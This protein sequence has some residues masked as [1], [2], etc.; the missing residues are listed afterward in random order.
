MILYNYKKR[1]ANMK[2]LI[3][4]ILQET[5]ENNFS[6]MD[7]KTTFKYLKDNKIK[8]YKY[9]NVDDNTINN[10]ENS[11]FYLSDFSEF[12]DPFDSNIGISVNQLYQFLL[13]HIN[14]DFAGKRKNISRDEVK[15]LFTEYTQ[16]N[17]D[18]VVEI[19]TRNVAFGEF[20]NKGELNDEEILRFFLS[21]KE[22]LFEIIDVSLPENI[23][24]MEN[25]LIKTAIKEAMSGL[26]NTSDIENAK[27]AFA[28]IDEPSTDFLQKSSELAN[29]FGKD[30]SENDINNV[31]NKIDE[32]IK[33]LY[34][35]LSKVIGVSCFSTSSD[36][37]L[38]WSH[39]A[40]KH[41]GVCIEYDF[42]LLEQ[43]ENI[44]AFL[45]PVMYS[46]ERP[47]LPFEKLELE[48]GQAKQESVIRIM[49]DLIRAILTKSKFW[50]YE[51]EW[52]F[53]ALAEPKQPV[54][55]PIISRIF[56]GSNI[57]EENFQKVVSAIG[58]RHIPIT[59]Y[60]LKR[61]KYEL[62]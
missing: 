47:L 52:R 5:S 45:L 14:L 49:P 41:R 34:I 10:I 24:T 53:I 40:N 19:L 44:N 11:A 22:L 16:G 21:N 42:S 50:D 33:G 15:S 29:L 46:N 8:L 57:T 32:M 62:E 13:P 43:L 61:D 39:Y 12:N 25:S 3:N 56:T 31:Y 37:I 51:N 9:C 23:E 55:L 1:G 54:K 48:N 27:K 4:R 7:C 6:K 60:S 58:N 20:I 26:K 36:N 18:E 2:N 17:E 59:K 30:I 28:I 38:M 35:Q